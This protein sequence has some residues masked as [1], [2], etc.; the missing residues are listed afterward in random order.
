MNLPK[1]LT[2]V[3]P[4][5]K[6]LA[7]FL[8]IILP[9][10][11]FY[12]GMR[13]QKSLTNNFSTQ[14]TPIYPNQYVTV[15]PTEVTIPS[16]ITSSPL[17]TRSV[18]T[19]PSGYVQYGMP[20]GCITLEKMQYCRTHA[21]P[22]CLSSETNISTPNGDV[23]VKDITVGMNVWTVNKQGQKIFEPVIKTGSMD[24]PTG[25]QMIHLV[26]RDGRNLFVSPGHPTTTNITIADL[27]VGE[28]YDNA[29][30]TS[31]KYVSYSDT[32]TYDILPAGDTGN[33][34]ANS[35]LVGSTL[36]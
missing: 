3:T 9:F 2:T 25:H 14:T 26:L 35:I 6:Y 27:K 23:N 1:S 18:F 24:V 33:Y 21:C 4:F 36:H 32:K 28:I 15:I 13:Y 29:V 22:I 10:V 20:L 34:F 7:M 16:D 19:C 8:F 31:M 17:P 12:L 30:I 11:G 5:S